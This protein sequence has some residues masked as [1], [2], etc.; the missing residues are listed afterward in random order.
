MTPEKIWAEDE[1]EFVEKTIGILE[2]RLDKL[3]RPIPRFKAHR[4]MRSGAEMRQIREQRKEELIPEV[5]RALQALRGNGNIEITFI[6]DQEGKIVGL[7]T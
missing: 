5:E 7:K 6:R 3:T 2:F 4:Q 1:R